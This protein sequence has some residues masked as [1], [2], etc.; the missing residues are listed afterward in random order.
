MMDI[1]LAPNP[2]LRRECDDIVIADEVNLADLAADMAETMYAANGCGLAAPQVGISKKLIVV[3]VEYDGHKKNPLA[4]V[5]PVVEST[6]GELI[7]DE[8]GCLSIPGL[9]IQV[10]R[11]E[12][13]TI[14]A[15]TVEG[16]PVTIEAK[17]FLAR[18]LQHEIDHLR[19]VTLFETLP[20]VERI[21]KLNE[22]KQLLAS[23][24]ALTA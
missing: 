24:E 9:G 8:E 12:D 14:K 1:V 17:G 6:R 13:A 19:G 2:V 10:A 16:E 3:D 5:N 11:R 4:L 15:L 20:V 23:G 22:F 21:E 18:C 7:V